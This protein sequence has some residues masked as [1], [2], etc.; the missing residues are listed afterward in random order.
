MSA[1]AARVRDNPAQVS[2]YLAELLPP[3]AV[4][5]ELSGDGDPDDLL[6]AEKVCVARSAPRRQRDFAVGWA[7]ARR[8]LAGLGVKS[9]ALP[10]GPD[11][12]PQWPAEV[13]GSITHT[14]GFSAAAVGRRD[15]FRG[16]GL[17]AE[18]VSQV[19]PELWP[20]VF[21]ARERDWLHTLSA[22]ARAQVAAILFSAKESFYKCQYPI[23]GTW[24]E[25]GD[26]ELDLAG[27][28]LS[29][30]V[31]AV[32]PQRPLP[33]LGGGAV[34]GRFRLRDGVI[35]TGMALPA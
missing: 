29:T 14:R 8:A 11:Q 5:A 30:G 18:L 33:Q 23:T 34:L 7:C 12:A 9:C 4:I 2:T 17:D 20:Q 16:L 19:T 35:Y 28:D 25:F 22:P 31:F 27:W 21:T 1:R 15:R 10:V 32:R 13:I 6:P 26:V 3:G 24:L